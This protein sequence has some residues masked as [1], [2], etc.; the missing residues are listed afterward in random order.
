M[1]NYLMTLESL[2]QPGVIAAINAS[3]DDDDDYTLCHCV[4]WES[5]FI[6]DDGTFECVPSSMPIDPSDEPAWLT[7]PGLIGFTAA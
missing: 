1:I 4:M 3:V 7:L 2:Q 5:W 6:M